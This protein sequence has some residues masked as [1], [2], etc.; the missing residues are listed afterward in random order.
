[1]HKNV[2]TY[3][4]NVDYNNNVQECFYLKTQLGE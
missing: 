2:F 3:N 4:S 1:M